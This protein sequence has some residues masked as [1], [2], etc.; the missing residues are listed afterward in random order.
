MVFGLA[1]FIA[2]WYFVAVPV[3]HTENC[4]SIRNQGDLKAHNAMRCELLEVLFLVCDTDMELS[5][6]IKPQG[7]PDG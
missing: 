5:V 1:Y 6:Q 3:S 4:R 7:P 2:D